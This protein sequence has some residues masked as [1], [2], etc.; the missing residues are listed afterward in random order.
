MSQETIDNIKKIY[1]AYHTMTKGR[2]SHQMQWTENDFFNMDS[3]VFSTNVMIDGISAENIEGT[4]SIRLQLVLKFYMSKDKYYDHF[5]KIL[6]DL[7]SSGFLFAEKRILTVNNVSIN[8][9]IKKH[10]FEAD[11]MV[12]ST[13]GDPEP[14][15]VLIGTRCTFYCESVLKGYSVFKDDK[16]YASVN[17]FD[18]LD[19]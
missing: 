13:M 2:L 18:L 7:I 10:S 19:I 15:F 14:S 17:R 9:V 16:S 3:S 12:I 8:V 11:T 1:D 5:K 6:D 4:G